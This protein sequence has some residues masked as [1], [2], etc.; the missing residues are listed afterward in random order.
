MADITAAADD[1]AGAGLFGTNSTAAADITL[2][3]DE[4]SGSGDFDADA[5]SDLT[6]EPAAITGSQ[7]RQDTIDAHFI[8]IIRFRQPTT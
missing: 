2:G 4:A 1:L 5:T 3:T 8:R 7:K 6:L